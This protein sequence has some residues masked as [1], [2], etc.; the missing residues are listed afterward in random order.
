ME[1]TPEQLA[2]GEPKGLSPE[3]CA[4]LRGE[5]PEELSADADAF[6]AEWAP[7]A[8]PVSYPRSGGPRGP[9]V[10][11][12]SGISHGAALYRTRHGKD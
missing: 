4:R 9:E 12:G 10:A 2:A 8:P 11:T 1:P 3:M 7:P 6:L 5:T